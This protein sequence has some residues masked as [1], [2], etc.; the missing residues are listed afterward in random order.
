MYIII[1]SYAIKLEKE[2]LLVCKAFINTLLYK[3]S[4]IY[5]HYHERLC[6]GKQ[7]FNSSFQKQIK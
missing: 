2:F 6:T 1:F 5:Q 4:K 3:W 7:H